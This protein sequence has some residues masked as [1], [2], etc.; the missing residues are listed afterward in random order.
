MTP[1]RLI[2]WRHG[3]TLWND[4]HRFQGSKADIDLS[5]RGLEQARAAAPALAHLAPD[6]LVTSPLRRAVDTGQA[7]AELTGLTPSIDPR[8]TEIDVGSWTGLAWE[9]LT[10]HDPQ[11]V[12]AL[13]R[14]EDVRYG[15]DGE[16]PIEVGARVGE[17]LGD[18]AALGG[19]SLI[20]SHGLALQSGVANLLGWPT[21]AQAQTLAVMSNCAWSI[22]TRRGGERWQLAVWNTS[23]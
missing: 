17:A 9:E 18:C 11:A 12:A 22:L 8:L 6:R 16:T 14:G 19:T 20:V 10:S 3:Q 1:T 15:G 23:I 21:F 13:G 4:Q 7:V 2:L 5:P